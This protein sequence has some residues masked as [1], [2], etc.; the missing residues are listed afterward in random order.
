MGKRD[1][2][3]RYFKQILRSDEK[4]PKGRSRSGSKSKHNRMRV[5]EHMK[6]TDQNKLFVGAA[7]PE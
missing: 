7:A 6:E 1:I 4:G 3:D 5:P 2:S